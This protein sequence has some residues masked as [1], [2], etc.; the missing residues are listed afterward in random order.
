M[1]EIACVSGVRLL[2]D[3]LEGVLPAGVCT[4]LEA[5]VAGCQRCQAFIESYRETPRLLR[6][7]TDASLPSDVRQ[8]LTDFLRA[9]RKDG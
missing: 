3:Y 9:R 1:N 5:H 2:M 4:Q 7:A 8:S 6:E